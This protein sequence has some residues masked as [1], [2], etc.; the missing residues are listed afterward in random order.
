MST[1]EDRQAYATR[2]G[3]PSVEAVDL[4]E[5]RRRY[6]YRAGSLCVLVAESTSSEVLV[7]PAVYPLPRCPNW[8]LGVLNLRGSIIPF[9]NLGVFDANF[10]EIKTNLAIVIDEREKAI[11]VAI[12]G[13]PI[14]IAPTPVGVPP[15][16]HGALKAHVRQVFESGGEIWLE[17]D[18]YA[19][20][21]QLARDPEYGRALTRAPAAV[22]EALVP[23]PS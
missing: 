3:R 2:S 16:L 8:M 22:D 12:G 19:L 10:R 17:L 18:H 20:L 21:C 23:A 11:A 13:L 4:R 15:P 9:F 5:S 6:G 14:S 7:N 1:A